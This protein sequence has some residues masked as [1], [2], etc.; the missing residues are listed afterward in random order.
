MRREQA[1]L[2]TIGGEEEEEEE[3]DEEELPYNK[4]HFLK[5]LV[6]IISPQFVRTC[7]YFSW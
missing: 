2:L 7:L 6:I 5:P 4:C 3:E 1:S